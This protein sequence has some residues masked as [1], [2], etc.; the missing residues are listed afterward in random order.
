MSK[1]P[2]RPK[3]QILEDGVLAPPNYVER[4]CPYN[5]QV[6]CFKEPWPCP[7]RHNGEWPPEGATGCEGKLKV[8]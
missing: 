6:S 4:Q 1:K 7:R 5:W 8:G 3:Y 2:S